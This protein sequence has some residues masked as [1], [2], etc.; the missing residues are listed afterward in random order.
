MAGAYQ[1]SLA[2]AT[3]VIEHPH[4]DVAGSH[5]SVTASVRDGVA[6]IRSGTGQIAEMRLAPDG[7]MTKVGRNHYRL[8]GE[9][10]TVWDVS[11]SC[12]CGGG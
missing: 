2:R 10:G 6:R 3:V 8:T 5:P 7:G 12:G 11:K 4:G 9:D 1:L